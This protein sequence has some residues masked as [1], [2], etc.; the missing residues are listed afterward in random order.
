MKSVHKISTA[1]PHSQTNWLRDMILG[2]QD[3]LVNVLGIVL[4]VAAAGGESKILVAASLAAA[5]AEAVSMGAVAYTST[6]AEKDHYD[7]ELEREGYEI[8]HVPLKETEEVRE[9]YQSKGFSGD[10]LDKIVAEITGNRETWLKIMMT[11]ELGLHRVE[12]KAIFLTSAIV[13]TTALVAAF[14]PITPFFFLDRQTAVI[15]SLVA[16]SLTLFAIGVYEA[17]T[18][19]GHWL[20]NG[21]QMAVIGMGA[22]LV[23]FFIGRVFGT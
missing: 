12:N 11:E 13:G 10:L 6:L 1:E 8:D 23:G 2:G 15:V 20:K 3:G 14:I 18:Y 4:G 19:V 17:K 22:A 5:F 21:L 9:I 16:S 7:K